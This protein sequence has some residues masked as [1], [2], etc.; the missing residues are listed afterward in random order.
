MGGKSKKATIGYWYLPMFHHGLGVG[1]LDAFLEF[2][3]GDRTAWSGELTDTG[4]VHVDAPHLFG[5]EK[6]QGGIVGDMDV[7][8]GKADQMP[9]SYLLATLGPQVPAWRGIA[10]VVWKGGKYGAMNPYPQPA[11]YKIRRI[12]KGWDHDAC[13]YPEK[14]AIGMQMAPSVAVYFAIDLSGSMHYVGGNGRSRLDNMKTAL[15]AALDQLGQSIASGTAVD[16][17]L[18]G[19]GDAPDH[20]QT[21]LRRNCTAQGIAELKSWVAARQALYGTYFPAGT[22]DMPSFYA[23]APSNAVRVAFFMTDGEPDPP[24]ATLAQAARADVDQVAHLRCY[25]INIDLANTTYTDMVH[26][27][28]GTT[29]AVV[30]GGDATTMVGLIRSAIFTGVLAMNVAHVLY[31]ANTNAEMGREPLD[32]ID[33]ASF[34]AGADWYHSQGFGICTCF[35]PAAE[36][37]DAFSTRIQRLG[38]CS[39]SRDRTDGKLHLDIANGIYTLEALPILTDD[40]ILEWREHPSVFDNAVNSVSVTYFDPDQKT[41]ITTPPVQDLAL[42]Q[43]YGVIHQTIDYPEIPTAP[44]ALRIAAR[45]LRASVTPLRTFELKTTR[46]AYALRPNQY[47]R[48]QCPKRGIAD[49]V[50]IVGSTQSGSLKSGAI[51][52]LLTQDIYRLPVSFSVEM[53]ASRGA[54]PAQPPLPITSQHVFEAPYIE[55]V[56]SLPSRDLSALSADASYLLAVA[57]DPATSRNYTLQVDAGT[58]EYRVAGDGQWCPCAR[59]VAGDVTRIATEFSLT[60]PYRLDQVAIGSA[61]LWGSEIVRVDRITPVGRQ[62]R[63]TLGRGCGDTVA[64][65]HAA[66]ECIWFYED[67]AAADL[68]EYVKGETVNVALLTNTGSAQLSS[69]D[70]AALPLTFVGRAARPYPPGNVTIAAADWPE[71]VSGEFVVM[72]AHRARLTQAD[73]LVDDRMGS[74]TLPRNQRYGLRFTDSR[75]VLLIEHTRMGA[76]SATVSLNTTG[77]VTMELW[78]IDNGGTSLHTHRHAFVYTPTD[79]PPQD[80]TIS[81]ADA[82]P[83]F[84]GVIVDGGNLDG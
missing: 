52:L 5:G 38:G 76:D 71:A 55:L 25:G 73:Q 28:P 54:A 77:Q 60:D 46:A 3:G 20:R 32:G 45:E 62:L 7:L 34:R 39:V 69:A 75:G 59:I 9:H 82:M 23:A 51:T 21:L 27:V 22:M 10:T 19:F 81:A 24:S 6:D 33:A 18:A 63:I 61:A 16:I 26:N 29:S 65:I 56:R 2:R 68:T 35:D 83:V 37:A 1:P 80:S 57:H 12:L 15:N 72:W 74:V 42:I 64:A 49:M 30:L 70:A 40:A 11:S 58:G 48:L 13:W 53:A 4:T 67:N 43:A 36:S 50:C 78:S 31:Y 41:D 66:G 47:V 8:F 17:M 84:E 79:P 14:A 44:L